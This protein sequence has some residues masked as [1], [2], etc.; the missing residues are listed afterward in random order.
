MEFTAEE[1]VDLVLYFRKPLS[2]DYEGWSKEE[3]Y[4]RFEKAGF[5]QKNGDYVEL[6][7]EGEKYLHEFIH[8]E[9]KK[10]I[11]SIDK[12]SKK[13]CLKQAEEQFDYGSDTKEFLEYLFKN[14]MDRAGIEV[15]RVFSKEYGETI[16][17]KI[18]PV[19]NS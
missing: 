2:K 15:R 1:K 12:V 7:S 17:M 9:T 6:T 5:A 14:Q 3:L 4:R 13:I 8:S 11:D 10:I 19:K 16:E 18:V